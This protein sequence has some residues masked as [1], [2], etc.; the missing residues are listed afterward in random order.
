MTL[1]TLQYN[2]FTFY[3][4]VRSGKFLPI[5]MHNVLKSRMSHLQLLNNSMSDVNITVTVTPT[6]YGSLRLALHVRLALQQLQSLG[7]SEKDIDDV[8]GIFEDTNLY[9]LSATVLIASFH[10]SINLLQYWYSKTLFCYTS[11]VYFC[12]KQNFIL[13]WEDFILKVKK[14][15]T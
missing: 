13:P 2:I 3:F 1:Y 10:V 9:L 14:I 11:L 7:F 6:S 4:R 8:K 5:V 15:S 12:N